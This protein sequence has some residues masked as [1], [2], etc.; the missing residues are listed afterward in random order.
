MFDITY[1]D[2]AQ[3]SALI[4]A[5]QQG[6]EAAKAELFEAY[7]PAI[8][9]AARRF[10]SATFEYEDAYQEASIAF[11]DLVAQH[12]IE[13]SPVLAGHVK[14]YLDY[15]LKAVATDSTNSFGIPGRT[16]RRY[17]KIMQEADGDLIRAATLLG[18][19]RM[20]LQ[21]FLDIYNAVGT[22]SLHAA[23]FEDDSEENRLAHSRVRMLGR[24]D[25]GEDAYDSMLTSWE[26]RALMEELDEESLEVIRLAYGFEPAVIDGEAVEALPSDKSL[27]AY[28]DGTV[29][30]AMT[31]RH[32][33]TYSRQKAQRR[34]TGALK[35]MREKYAMTKETE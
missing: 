26:V 31:W 12:D 9:A 20:S 2:S 24:P 3:E 10:T 17:L 34:R 21:V 4:T 6:D 14:Q 22:T 32:G 15:H 23:A 5:A 13:R 7:H 27:T 33:T 8:E 35:I 11:L 30:A 29:A 28:D 1:R 25:E 19:Y 18:E 16:F